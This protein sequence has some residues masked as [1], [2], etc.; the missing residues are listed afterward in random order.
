MATGKIYSRIAT[1]VMKFFDP[2][3]Y[4]PLAQKVF[5]RLSILIKEVLPAAQIEH[6]GSSSIQGLLSKGDLDIFVGVEPAHFAEAIVTL[7]SLGFRVKHDSLRTDSLCPFQ[8]LIIR[9]T[10]VYNWLRLGRHLRT[11][12]FSAIK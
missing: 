11:F 5:S 9:W 6:I 12:V 3:D 7:E 10:W 1:G 2:Q 4:Q 8:L